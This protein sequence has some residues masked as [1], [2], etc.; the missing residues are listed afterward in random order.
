MKKTLATLTLSAA[1]IGGPASGLAL[2]ETAPKDDT[3]YHPVASQVENTRAME[4]FSAKVGVGT[5]VGALTG[6][7]IGFIIGCAIGGGLTAPTVVFI[8]LGC[9]TGGVTGASI[10]GVVGT[11]VVGG[12]TAV[13]AGVEMVSVLL[14][15][16]A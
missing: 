16:A 1:L 3:V 13:I 11:L 14:T 9:L 8:P 7:G 12:P 15:P 2:A 4:A 6:T 5:T 10:G